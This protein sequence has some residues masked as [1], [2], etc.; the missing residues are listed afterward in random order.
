MT[1]PVYTQTP[2]IQMT[3]NT[4]STPT[5]TRGRGT[6]AKRGRKPRGAFPNV[7][8]DSPRPSPQSVP[9]TP[10]PTTRFTPVQ[11]ATPTVPASAT[12]QTSSVTIPVVS[13]TAANAGDVSMD[14][15]DD[16]PI[17]TLPAPVIAAV[18]SAATAV[19]QPGATA[20]QTGVPD[21][22]ADGEDELLPAMADDDYSAQLSWQS[23]SKDNLK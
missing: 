10:N 2:F 9:G 19:L 1:T 20:R 15:G 23:E 13:N 6:G 4:P 3:H 11:W 16:E 8:T 5:P 18:S 12:A 7:S 22:D 14:S 17:A 21:E